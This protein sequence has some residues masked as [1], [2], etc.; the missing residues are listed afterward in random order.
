MERF[1]IDKLKLGE[2]AIVDQDY[3]D[4]AIKLT[5]ECIELL[6]DWVMGRQYQNLV[7]L[8]I[9]LRGPCC[10]GLRFCSWAMAG[11]SC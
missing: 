10:S 4:K 11:R 2:T 6:R 1:N 5:M 8:A 3:F 7:L 9:P